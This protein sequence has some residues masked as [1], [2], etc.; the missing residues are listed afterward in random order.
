MTAADRPPPPPAAAA[1][2][3]TAL[4]LAGCSAGSGGGTSTGSGEAGYVNSGKLTIGTAEP[5]YSPYVI[6]DKPQSGK[7]FEAAVAYA[8]ADKL[9]FKKGDVT[10]VRT[11]FDQAIASLSATA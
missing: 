4:A 11:T 6:D 2:A 9:G 5:A 1:A 10:W 7:G 8:V 3:A